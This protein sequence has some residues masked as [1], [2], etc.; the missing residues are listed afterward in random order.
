[1]K[2]AGLLWHQRAKDLLAWLIA[3]VHDEYV[4]E[5]HKNDAQRAGDLMAKCIHDAGE[6]LKLRCPMEGDTPKIGYSWAEIH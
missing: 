2:M 4:I 6:M 1:M 5:A 3:F